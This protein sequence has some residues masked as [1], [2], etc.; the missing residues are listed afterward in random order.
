M[1]QRQGELVFPDGRRLSATYSL[2]ESPTG[3][4]G[5]IASDLSGIDTGVLWSGLTLV[6]DDGRDLKVILT[7][8]SA[9][10]AP[11]VGLAASAASA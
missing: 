4:A 7:A 6:T 10:G 5:Q 11:F 9:R 8:V 2:S 3:C 1:D